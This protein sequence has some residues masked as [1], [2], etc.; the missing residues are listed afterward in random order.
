[1]RALHEDREVMRYIAGGAERSEAQTGASL[2][3]GLRLAHENSGLGVWI[4][5]EKASGT[6]VAN[7]LLRPPATAEPMVGLEIGYALPRAQWGKGFA[8]EMVD[9]FVRYGFETLEATRIL[10]LVDP[11]HA[12]SRKVLEKAGFRRAGE[13][14]YRDPLTRRELVSDLLEILRS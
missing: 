2:D 13:T 11:G 12:V 6:P 8:T 9:R 14:K 5:E 7:I 3:A 1:L 10:A 4:A